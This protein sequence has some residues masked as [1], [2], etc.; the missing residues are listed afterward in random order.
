M[1]ALLVALLFPSTAFPLNSAFEPLVACDSTRLAALASFKGDWRV[2]SVEPE[3]APQRER[4]GTAT[5]SAIAGG[6]ALREDLQLSDEYHEMR[7]LAFDDRGGAWQLMVIDSEHGNMVLMHGHQVADGLEFI[8][9][10]QRPD[11]LLID[12]VSFRR[13]PTG[14]R[15]RIETAAGY[16]A[17]WRLL[18]EITYTRVP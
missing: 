7:I 2:R 17:P 16:G 15:S 14:W 5:I 10:Q 1:L 8:S 4:T 3:L 6:C 13:V 9:T 18:R 12:R 11:R